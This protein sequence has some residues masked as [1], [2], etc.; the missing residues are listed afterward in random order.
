MPYTG[1][2]FVC[3]KQLIYFK[4]KKINNNTNN[5]Y[6][7]KVQDFEVQGNDYNKEIN[8]GKIPVAI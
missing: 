6:D 2:I 5:F 3:I 4:K 7:F 8:I 1:S